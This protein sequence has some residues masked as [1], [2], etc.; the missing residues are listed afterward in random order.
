MTPDFA[1]ARENMVDCQIRTSDVTSTTVLDAFLEVPREAFVPEGLRPLAYTDAE[2]TIDGGRCLTPPAALA[3]L[4]QAAGPKPEEVVLLV[5]CASG[6]AA[7]ILSSMV[8]SVVALE[9]DSVLA[10][11]ATEALGELG[12]GNVA[13]VEGELQAGYAAEGPYDLIV[14]NGA[15]G[16]LPGDIAG[17]LKEGGRLVAVVGSGNS[18]SARLYVN[19]EGRLSSRHLFNCALAPLPGLQKAPE[20]EF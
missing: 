14:I 12:Y 11:Q 6:Y 5:G 7:A 17:Q 2:L 10:G 4:I 20:F 16:H 15:I 18:A 19:E 13:V 3:K 9:A 8:S 1:H